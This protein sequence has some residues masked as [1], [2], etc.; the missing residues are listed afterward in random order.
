MIDRKTDNFYQLS[1]LLIFR[2]LINHEIMY[3]W[4]HYKIGQLSK[5]R[6]FKTN[7]WSKLIFE[8]SIK[9]IKIDLKILENLLNY[10]ITDTKLKLLDSTPAHF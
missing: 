10:S 9:S 6:Y 5:N 2:W 3:D 4:D 8:T 7:F 1:I